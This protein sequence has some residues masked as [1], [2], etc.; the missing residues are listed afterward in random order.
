LKQ[1]RKIVAFGDSFAWGDE[2]VA[3][4]QIRAADYGNRQYREQHC[5][6][7]I[8]ANH[9]GVVAENFAF[10]G[11]S[12]QSTRWIY[13]WW[14][15]Q[16][17]EP[18]SC[19]VLVQLSGPWRSSQFDQHRIQHET[20]AKWNR[21]IHSAWVESYKH[22]HAIAYQ[23]FMAEQTLADCEFRNNLV[24][25]E[26]YLFFQGQTTVHPMLMF[27]SQCHTLEHGIMTDNLLWQ[28]HDLNWL[29]PEREFWAT[30]GHLN[31]QG[32]QKLADILIQDIDRV[33]L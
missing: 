20:D 13:T 7:G 23:Y 2:L 18:G 30:N 9:Y 32:H 6:T 26:T 28:G 16:E 27:N 25:A 10:P 5:Y 11:G 29:L 14:R 22:N 12:C 19:L 21:F 8:L 4:D 33:I 17:P 31:E 1:F 15:Q 24:Q 3:S